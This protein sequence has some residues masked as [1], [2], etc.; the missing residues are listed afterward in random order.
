M[1]MVIFVSMVDVPCGGG[2]NAEEWVVAT[3]KMEKE[4]NEEGFFLIWYQIWCKMKGK[5]WWGF[6]KEHK[7]KSR[8]K[9]HLGYMSMHMNIGD[10]YNMI[11]ISRH[12]KHYD[13]NAT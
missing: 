11:Q 9:I 3:T 7:Y 13:D 12:G 8:Y 10:R 2:T 6:G 5:A 4:K 1:T